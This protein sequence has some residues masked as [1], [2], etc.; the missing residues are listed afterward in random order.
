MMWEN[1]R[2]SKIDHYECAI[3][4]INNPID[5]RIAALHEQAK[6]DMLSVRI[7]LSL[8]CLMYDLRQE[9][10]YEKIA[11][12]VMCRD[13]SLSQHYIYCL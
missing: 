10:L 3:I 5:I 7:E 13:S 8:L 6:L 1:Y 2:N 12:R 11:N 9:N 4:L